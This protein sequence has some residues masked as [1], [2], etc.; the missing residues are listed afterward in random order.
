VIQRLADAI[1]G[2]ERVEIPGAGHLPVITHAE[3]CTALLR[4]LALPRR[5]A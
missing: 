2:C 4:R 1:P 3:I 5:D